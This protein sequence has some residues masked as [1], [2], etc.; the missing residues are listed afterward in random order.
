LPDLGGHSQKKANVPED[1][2]L[3]ELKSA[4]K[5]NSTARL[6]IHYS[7]SGREATA[8]EAPRFS[9]RFLGSSFFGLHVSQ[10]FLS[11]RAL[12]QQRWSHSFPAAF[13]RVQQ[14]W[15][16]ATAPEAQ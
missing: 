5:K 10:T 7:F 14:V 9:L 3:A 6:L 2:G 4:L 8:V 11:F 15:P 12:T 16:V 1:I 13:A